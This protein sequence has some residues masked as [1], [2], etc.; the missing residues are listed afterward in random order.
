V[1]RGRQVRGVVLDVDAGAA[2]GGHRQQRGRRQR[3]L[4]PRA[5]ALSPYLAHPLSRSLSR[6]LARSLSRSCSRFSHSPCLVTLFPLPPSISPSLR[7]SCM[8]F[9]A[10]LRY[11]LA[12]YP[13]RSCGASSLAAARHAWPSLPRRAAMHPLECPCC[14]ARKHRT[15]GRPPSGAEGDPPFEAPP[16]PPAALQYCA[17]PQ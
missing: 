13:L 8:P 3:P 6:S 5:A 4:G 10:P 16:A 12:L 17:S 14:T 1:R 7:P 15:G 11:S 2:G 9:F